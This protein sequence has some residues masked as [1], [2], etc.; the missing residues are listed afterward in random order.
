MGYGVEGG[1]ALQEYLDQ[2]LLVCVVDLKKVCEQEHHCEN[3]VLTD[4]AEN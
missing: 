1:M 2:D 4:S 3:Q